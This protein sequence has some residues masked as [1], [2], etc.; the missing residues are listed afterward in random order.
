MEYKNK[1]LTEFKLKERSMK[2]ITEPGC[3]HLYYCS[4]VSLI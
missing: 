2:I 3:A 1:P 4:G